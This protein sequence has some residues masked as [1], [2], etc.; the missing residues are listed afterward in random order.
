MVVNRF[1]I[2]V[3]AILGRKTA[4]REASILSDDIIIVSYPK[5]GNTWTRFLIANLLSSEA[6]TFSNIENII[7]DIYQWDDAYLKLI[8]RPR[9]LKSHEYFEPRYKKTIYIVRDPRD[10]VI[11]YWY[12]Q[13]KFGTVDKNVSMDCFVNKFIMGKLDSY[14]SWGE[15]VGSWLGARS[16]DPSF[17]LVRYEDLLTDPLQEMRRIQH[18][19]GC[20]LTESNILDAIENSSFKK[21]SM[22]EEKEFG[23]WKPMRG[24]NKDMPFVR[25]GKNGGWKDNLSGS[26]INK[27]ETEWASVMKKLGYLG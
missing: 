25:K 5:S 24:S 2:V 16:N 14:G 7:P 18:F 6:V 19:I 15:N 17:L 4:G 9:V 3:K 11:S 10:V 1:K 12:H 23:K 20:D 26:A 27:I 21:M 22:M 13:L 8:K